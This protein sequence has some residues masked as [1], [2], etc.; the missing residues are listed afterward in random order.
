MRFYDGK[1]ELAEKLKHGWDNRSVS[2]K[3]EKLFDWEVHTSVVEDMATQKAD[4]EVK[5]IML[6]SDQF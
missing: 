6:D 3:G 4:S 2:Q 1:C 5:P